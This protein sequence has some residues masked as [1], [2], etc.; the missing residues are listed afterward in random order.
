LTAICAILIFGIAGNATRDA[1]Y[2][3]TLK[4]ELTMLLDG[5]PS[6]E[7]QY[8]ALENLRL[9]YNHLQPGVK[10]LGRLVFGT[11][12]TR[13]RIRE[14]Y[15]A[16]SGQIM[17]TP[18]AKFLES[19]MARQQ[20]GRRGEL[21]AEEHQQLYH[22]LKTYL[23]LTGGNQVKAGDITPIAETFELSLKSSYGSQYQSIDEKII[24]DN[25]NAIIKF[26]ADGLYGDRA[27][28]KTIQAAR[29]RLTAA[30]RA[31]AVYSS[32]MNRLHSQRSPVPIA[33]IIGRTESLKFGHSVSALYTRDAWEQI[34]YNEMINSSKDPFKADW[35]MG[36]VKVQVDEAKLLSELVSLYTDDLTRRWLDFIRNTHITF[37]SDLPSLAS[38]LERMSSRESEIKRMLTVVCSLATQTRDENILPKTAP[39][40]VAGL[41]DQ[42]T[43]VSNKIIGTVNN[44]TNNVPD[45]FIASQKTFAPLEN[46]LKDGAFLDYQSSLSDLSEKIKSCDSRGGF[47]QT[48]AI[49]GDDPIKICRDKI[50]KTSLNVPTA[51][52]ASLKRILESPLDFTAGALAKKIS[53]ELEESWNSEVVTHYNDKLKGRYPLDKNGNDV[54]WNDFEEF[55]K[56]QS[57]I[58][59]KYYDKNLAGLTERTHRGYDKKS[60]HSLSIPISINDE[61]INTYNRA[62]KITAAFFKSD[63]SQKRHE[64][65]FHPFLSSSGDV[66]FSIGDKKLDF[67]GGLPVTVNRQ[68]GSTGDETIILRI[69]TQDKAQEEMRFRGE[70][71]TMRFLNAG[72]ISKSGSD[73][74][75]I[76]W[77]INVRNIYTAN[78]TSQVRSNAEV[79]FEESI[80]RGF[81][82]PQ[83]VA[84]GK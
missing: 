51:V 47:T 13:G 50:N 35:V 73:K 14:A 36:P 28:Q 1:L 8:M 12:K 26:A 3:R 19:S 70:W 72:K 31:A 43:N 29:D 78:I 46:F 59:W 52:S 27:D 64:I 62:D 69:T 37:R 80:T 42:I 49:R 74:Y 53:T 25:I 40:S 60:S 61:I 33:Q 30:P 2:M 6:I 76:T 39:K 77:R 17:I 84:G 63:G 18:A 16:A 45:P 4:A 82:V 57:G 23:L 32:I 54:S 44:L 66:Y 67:Q 38:D 21:T 15:I 58:L 7:N 10:S 65:A 34:V 83:K 20:S 9:S 71:G 75:R 56:P 11:D 55:F 81:A 68:Q 41:K 24:K 48:F 22:S 5:N 79:M